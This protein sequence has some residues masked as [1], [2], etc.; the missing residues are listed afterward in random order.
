MAYGVG[1]PTKRHP[2]SLSLSSQC[3][4]FYFSFPFPSSII[5]QS[6]TKSFLHLSHHSLPIFCQKKL[7]SLLLHLHLL[8]SLFEQ[9]AFLFSLSLSLLSTSNQAYNFVPSVNVYPHFLS[10]L[11][12]SF[13]I[14]F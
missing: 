9:W 4:S 7:C 3:R 5:K 6:I 14:P 13:L 1:C 2:H 10:N 11:S 12:L 8:F